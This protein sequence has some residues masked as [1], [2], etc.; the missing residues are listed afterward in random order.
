MGRVGASRLGEAPDRKQGVCKIRIKVSTRIQ[1]ASGI[2]A[3]RITSLCISLRADPDY[4]VQRF[5]Q[6]PRAPSQAV[7]VAARN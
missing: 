6:A 1:R 3:P 7:R 5:V 4:G 2:A